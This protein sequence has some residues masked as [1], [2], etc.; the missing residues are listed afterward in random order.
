M[1]LSWIFQVAFFSVLAAAQKAGIRSHL[2]LACWNSALKWSFEC[3]A[4]GNT[5]PCLC[6]NEPF[7]GTVISCVR[8][9]VQDEPSINHAYQHIENTCKY[10]GKVNYNFGQLD[11]IYYYQRQNLI[12]T[13][14]ATSI[15]KANQTYIHAAVNTET[16]AFN[17]NFRAAYAAKLQYDLGTVFGCVLIFYW[18]CVAFI[19]SSFNY[20]SLKYPE[21]L[22]KNSPTMNAIRKYLVL[23]ATFKG[24]HGRPVKLFMKL[25]IKAPTRGQSIALI[26]YFILNVVLTCVDYG[27]YKENVYL[28][29]TQT[30]LVRYMGNRT[31]IIAFTQIPLVIVLASRNNVFIKLTGW[32]YDTMQVYH[33]WVARVMMA[34]AFI[35][36]VCFTIIAIKGHTVA[37]RWQEV[38]NWRFGNM[39]TYAGI[40]MIITAFNAFRARFYDVFYFLHKMFYVVFI[41]G[42]ARHTYDFGWIGWVWASIAVHAAERFARM[43]NT[44]LSGFHNEAYAELFDDDTFRVSVKYSKR[45]ALGPGQYCYIRILHKN[46]FW[47]A[48]PFSVYSSPDEDNQN[49][50][51]AIKAQKGATRTIRD[52]LN[53]QP[54]RSARLPVMIEGPYGVHAP[55]EKYDTVFLIAGGMGV[56]ATYSYALHLKRLARRGQKIVFLWAIQNTAPLEW[57]GEELLSILGDPRIEVQIYISRK[58]SARTFS[59]ADSDEESDLEDFDLEKD[60][61]TVTTRELKSSS[62]SSAEKSSRSLQKMMPSQRVIDQFGYCLYGKR[63]NIQEEITKFLNGM[64]GN[65]AIVS[66][67]PAVLVDAIRNGIVGNLEET[68]GRVDYFEEAFSW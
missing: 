8:V 49:I 20:I 29:D 9:R 62:G 23:P 58:F 7:L 33:R 19:G 41:I 60:G 32:S 35:H 44:V 37:Y 24:M 2:A 27:V 52:Y 3:S 59:G 22:F 43:Y 67:G 31:G 55:V 64:N 14:E 57:F 21:L 53:A 48:H 38:I 63:P 12:S 15:M 5:V 54:D 10:T 26:T 51:F 30:Q 4:G 17:D 47:Q 13:D 28:P 18:A 6:K 36:S 46:L 16:K 65:M 66:C 25:Y 34:H 42:I 39:A 11:E 68:E 56:T 45:W 40:I 50:Q 1:L 61:V